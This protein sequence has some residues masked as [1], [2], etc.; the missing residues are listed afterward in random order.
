VAPPAEP[1]EDPQ[2]FDGAFAALADGVVQVR[3]LLDL[4]AERARMRARRMLERVRNELCIAALLLVAVVAGALFVVIGAVGGLRALFAD[5]PWLGE[6]AAGVLLLGA[7][8]ATMLVRSLRREREELHRLEE[9]YGAL[10]DDER[11]SEAAASGA[12]AR[13]R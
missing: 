3:T 13:T 6:L 11:E 12:P 10:E 5:Q 2:P 1:R 9:K 7:A 8:G 4:R